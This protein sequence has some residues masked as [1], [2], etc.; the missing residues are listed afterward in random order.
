VLASVVSG[1]GLAFLAIPFN[2]YVA[3]LLTGAS[4]AKGYGAT[5][6]VSVLASALGPLAAAEAFNLAPDVPTG[7][8]WNA[9]LFAAVALAGLLLSLGLPD[10]RPP[11]SRARL[12]RAPLAPDAAILP[13]AVL[14]VFAGLS[15]GA[16]T[17]YFAVHF[18]VGLRTPPEAWGVALALATAASAL[19][20]WLAGRLATRWPAGPLLVAGQVLAVA[21]LAPFALAAPL[22]A[23]LAGFVLRYV[24]ANTVTPL[25]N[26]MM[27][28]D[29]DPGGRGFAQG[30]ASMAWNLGWAGGALAGG[31]LLAR[32]GGA[33]F[34]AGAALGVAGALAGLG[35]ARLRRPAA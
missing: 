3:D 18:L 24:F 35:V 21:C 7:L 1:T 32:W 25:A 11:T 30:F 13:V 14:Y 28:G 31:P 33:L 23:L 2:S 29:V 12:A 15:F 26:V 10:A 20:F 19:G 8:R 22:A 27:M 6:A 16:T 4:M 34:P 5:G 9:L 17:P